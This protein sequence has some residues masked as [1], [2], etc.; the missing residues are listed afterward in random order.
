MTV[1][2]TCSPCELKDK[3]EGEAIWP[4]PRQDNMKVIPAGRDKQEE[5]AETKVTPSGMLICYLHGW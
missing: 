1:C 5:L 3:N 2:T 4:R